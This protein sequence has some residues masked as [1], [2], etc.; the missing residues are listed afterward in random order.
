M[1]L[2]RLQSVFNNIDQNDAR[3]TDDIPSPSIDTIGDDHFYSSGFFDSINQI[4]QPD[5]TYQ[6][7]GTIPIGAAAENS[8]MSRKLIL[9]EAEPSTTYYSGYENQFGVRIRDVQGVYTAHQGMNPNAVERAITQFDDQADR[10]SEIQTN[11]QV[12]F[13]H[14]NGANVGS[15][16]VLGT[17]KYV[18]EEVYDPTHGND[19]SNRNFFLRSNAGSRENL[20]IK[21]YGTIGRGGLGGLLKEP[22]IVHNIPDSRGAA[23][24]QGLG[25][26]REGIPFRAAADDVL[27]VLN[28]TTSPKGL[29]SLVKENVTNFQIGDGRLFIDGKPVLDNP[30]RG[31]MAPPIPFPNTGFLNFLHGTVQGSSLI[32]GGGSARKPFMIEYSHRRRYGFPY[33]NLGDRPVGLG[34]LDKIKLPIVEGKTGPAKKLAQLSRAILK[35]LKEKG[36]EE[37]LRVAELPKIDPP[38]PFM[39]LGGGKKYN[40]I[41]EFAKKAIV[42]KEEEFEFEQEIK[43]G[44][45][46]V[47][48]KDLRGGRLL[49]F[50]G[51]VTGINEN[52]TPSYSSTQYIGRS[53]DVYTYQKAERDLSFNLRVYPF[54]I[55]EHRTILQ[56][57]E[58]LTSL[59]YPS[60]LD[61]EGD[62]FSRMQAPFTELHMAHIG[63]RDKGQFGFIKSLTYTVP[64]GG[65]WDSESTTPKLFDIAISYQILHRRP[66]SLRENFK[67]YRENWNRQSPIPPDDLGDFPGIGD[68]LNFG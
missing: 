46:Y 53:E 63:N 20:D 14:I 64:D 6:P 67:F 54:D 4:L 66:P 34:A 26:N 59:A 24:A 58:A 51:F 22:Y 38:T 1:A 37:L 25:Y 18:L 45:F 43:R 3:S 60:Y 40:P 57:I 2:E 50:R 65:D 21:G 35:P 62:G 36:E 12:R 11:P 42:D 32:P 68:D 39:G 33:K 9:S 19:Y 52:I 41:D 44:D 27:R 15:D 31:T 29:E 56:K 23:I 30:L 49:Y 47:K 10:L 13:T 8:P 61:G 7:Y 55:R 5:G 48:I 28:Y 17:G 16:N